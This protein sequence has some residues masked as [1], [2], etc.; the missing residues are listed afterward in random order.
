MAGSVALEV[1]RKCQHGRSSAAEFAS[2]ASPPDSSARFSGRGDRS[3]AACG[4]GWSAP[5]ACSRRSP[6]QRASG[7]RTSAVLLADP[8]GRSG[9]RE[10]RSLRPGRLKVD[11][12]VAFRTE[13][14]DTNE[15]REGKDGV[16]RTVVIG[17]ENPG[18]SR[19]AFWRV[20]FDDGGNETMAVATVGGERR[21]R[22]AATATAVDAKPR[23]APGGLA[24][25]I[26]DDLAA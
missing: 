21:C 24:R 17:R 9:G 25:S 19:R 8:A 16:A 1:C 14:P 7:G 23:G 6:A 10:L 2:N 3:V 22:L 13:T 20:H 12:D 5:H 15:F 11:G 18:G 4:E 26:P